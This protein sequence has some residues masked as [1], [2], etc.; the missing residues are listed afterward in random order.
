MCVRRKPNSNMKEKVAPD[1]LRKN[2]CDTKGRACET[3]KFEQSAVVDDLKVDEFT[4]INFREFKRFGRLKFQVRIYGCYQ[5]ISYFVEKNG[6]VQS[7]NYGFELRITMDNVCNMQES[8][9]ACS[10]LF[11]FHTFF[12]FCLRADEVN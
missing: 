1:G 10:C 5:P 6:W 7:C 3:S 11:K 4:F 9:L 2:F 12:F 8:A